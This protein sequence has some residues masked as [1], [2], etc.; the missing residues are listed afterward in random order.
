M[1]LMDA[2]KT[3]RREAWLYPFR[4]CTHW[5]QS[6]RSTRFGSTF[7]FAPRNQPQPQK[8]RD[9]RQTSPK[10]AGRQGEGP[11]APVWHIV[12]TE[13]R[14]RF[15]G[16]HPFESG[17]ICGTQTSRAAVA[18][19]RKE[20]A[21]CGRLKTALAMAEFRAEHGTDSKNGFPKWRKWVVVGEFADRSTGLGNKPRRRKS[22]RGIWVE[23]S[24]KP[25]AIRP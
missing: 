14:R 19:R 16:A 22:T 1:F 25:Q 7:C 15:L 11:S 17:A 23:R 20:L 5:E 12:G 21:G 9:R 10:G 18:L 4:G 24:P 3:A 6:E 8:G 13:F 2:D